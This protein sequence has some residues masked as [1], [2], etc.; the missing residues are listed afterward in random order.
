[1]IGRVI[2]EQGWLESRRESSCSLSQLYSSYF[3]AALAS[4]LQA[5]LFR[6]GSL[7]NDAP[8]TCV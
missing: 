2:N 5:S 6:P 1:V 3:G 4:I 7:R 8:R